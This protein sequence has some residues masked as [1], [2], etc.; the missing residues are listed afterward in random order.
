MQQKLTR[1][2]LLR[3][4]SVAS[5]L[6][7]E[8]GQ[9]KNALP[10][11]FFPQ[12]QRGHTPDESKRWKGSALGNLYPFIKQ[13]QQKTRQGLA[14]LHHRPTDLEVWKAKGRDKVFDLMSYRPEATA[15]RAQI[16]ERVDKGEYI[17]E[18]LKFWASQDVEVP[19][20]FLI[21]KRAKFP[22]PAVVAL[23][24]HGGFYY[25][26]KEKL[27]ET[28]SEHPVLAAYRKEY[29]DGVS[30][31]ASLARHGYAV[32]V[33]DMFYHGER[34]L[35]LDQDLERGVNDRSKLEPAETIRKINE[36]ASTSEEIVF[37]N[38][39]HSGFTWGGVLV[40]DDMRAVD[41]LQSRP[42]VDPNRIACAGLS[43]G[44]WRTVFLAGL[45]PRIK[46]ACVV[47]WMT[48]FRYLMPHHEVYTVPSA[49]VPGLLEYLDYPDVASLAMPNPLLVVHGQHDSLF[50]SDGVRAAI[51]NLRQCYQAIARPERFD[52]LFFDG[53]HKFPFQAQQRMVDWFDRWV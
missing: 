11:D 37:R 24:D 41:Y 53:P 26:G 28:E 38:I 5:L 42:E 43:M 3:G 36:R 8:V 4:L 52:T 15:P 29:Y 14:F 22:V 30:F 19:C 1:R 13:Q 33:T 46:A 39:L 6:A 17:R 48:S 44:G 45:D 23:H 51:D 12:L 40:W 25:W 18:S 10:S 20:Y 35:I 31:P 7:A 9:P 34:R 32:I 47:G 2:G 16:F 27:V 21:P 49:M 50:P